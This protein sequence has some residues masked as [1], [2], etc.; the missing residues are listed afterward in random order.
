V[1]KE[2]FLSKRIAGYRAAAFLVIVSLALLGTSLR[3]EP[4]AKTK[5]KESGPTRARIMESANGWLHVK[6]EWIHPEGYKFV[7]N[8]VI[9]TTAKIGRSF[10]KPPGKLALENPAML[11]SRSKTAPASANDTRTPAEKA[12]EA[13]QKNLTPTAAPQTGTHL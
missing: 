11:E 10:P 8:K 6:G 3:A 9:R 12:A 7:N 5:V 2:S 1:E 4:P 13:R